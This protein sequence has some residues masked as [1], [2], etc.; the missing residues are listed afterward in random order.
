MSINEG[1]DYLGDNLVPNPAYLL[2]ETI[3]GPSSGNKRG[4]ND[5]EIGN[6]PKKK[7]KRKSRSKRA[8]QLL[9]KL[10]LLIVLWSTF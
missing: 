7:Q 3:A 2:D 8:A 5:H 9:K 4:G 1:L 10:D 6:S